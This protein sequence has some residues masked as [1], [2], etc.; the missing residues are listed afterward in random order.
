MN[1]EQVDEDVLRGLSNGYPEC[2]IAYYV[3][4]WRYMWSFIMYGTEEEREFC[5]KLVDE[6][7]TK[8]G[9]FTGYIKCPR[10]LGE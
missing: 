1:Q 10:C 6:H 9:L 7:H 8:Q 4:D 2:C 5:N 3:T